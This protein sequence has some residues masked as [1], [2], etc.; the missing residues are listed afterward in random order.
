M[1]DKT[2]I[3]NDKKFRLSCANYGL[4][5]NCFI[6]RKD[7]ILAYT[8]IDD[9][10]VIFDKNYNV[11]GVEK[12]PGY[13]FDDKSFEEFY[14]R[15]S[16]GKKFIYPFEDFTLRDFIDLASRVDLIKINKDRSVQTKINGQVFEKNNTENIEY[17]ELLSYIKF[18]GERIK[19]YF[20][21]S[22]QI[23]IMGFQIVDVHSYV[24][25]LIHKINN[26]VAYSFKKKFISS[27][28][29]ML[30]DIGLPDPN[31]VVLLSDIADLLM[32][33]NGLKPLFGRLT[34][35]LT[36]ER[37]D[38]SMLAKNLLSLLEISED[39]LKEVEE[40]NNYDIKSIE[41]LLEIIEKKDFVMTKK[42]LHNCC[43]C[44]NNCL[45]H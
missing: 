42:Q 1:M 20:L 5:W 12:L 23:Q 9:L 3:L 43:N 30:Q 35:D 41:S 24:R 17:F 34:P 36:L 15:Y 32:R 38:L 28:S 8:V 29:V 7:V 2:S 40:Q 27:P 26:S 16:N 14:Q 13:P 44:P 18:I 37:K 45:K 19:Q 33:Q 4:N 22:Y 10:F 11:I 21:I 39:E 25:Q 31:F 6:V